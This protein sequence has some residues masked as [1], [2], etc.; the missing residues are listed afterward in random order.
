MNNDDT[1]H[2]DCGGCGHCHSCLIG[3]CQACWLGVP[4][5]CQTVLAFFRRT[6]EWTVCD[7]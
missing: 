2:R 1:Q 6:G 3:G 4:E 7:V 5:A